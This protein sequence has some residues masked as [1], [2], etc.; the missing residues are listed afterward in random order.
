MFY[1]C[2]LLYFSKPLYNRRHLKKN[3]FYVSFFLPNCC[4]PNKTKCLKSKY[5]AQQSLLKIIHY[6]KTNH[7]FL[8]PYNQQAQLKPTLVKKMKP[9]LK[10]PQSMVQLCFK[11][12]IFFFLILYTDPKKILYERIILSIINMVIFNKKIIIKNLRDFINKIVF[13]SFLFFFCFWI[14]STIY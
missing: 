6:Q 10:Q 1:F 2:F 5:K 9:K 12:L 7:Y 11:Y 8:R 13:F 4:L 14:S 3:T